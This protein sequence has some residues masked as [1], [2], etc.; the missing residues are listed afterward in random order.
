MRYAQYP[1]RHG[2]FRDGFGRKFI[3]PRPAFRQVVGNAV[4]MWNVTIVVETSYSNERIP[5]VE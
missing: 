5:I 4:A 3:P 2:F 1:S